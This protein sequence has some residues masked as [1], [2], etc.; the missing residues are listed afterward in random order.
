MAGLDPQA[1]L[2]RTLAAAREVTGARYAAV[3]VLNEER[4]ELQEFLT[5]GMDEQTRLAIGEWPRGRGVLGVLI[6]EPHPLRLS[7]VGQ[8]PLSF[9]FPEGHPAMSSFLGV[10]ILIEGVAS[11]S[12]YVAEKQGGEFTEADEEAAVILA[13]W[14][15]SAIKN[16]RRYHTFER[17]RVELEHTVRGLDT[18]PDG[19]NVIGNG[20]GLERVLELI[21]ER[22][23]ALIDARGTNEG[24]VSTHEEKLLREF[25]A[26][27]AGAVAMAQTEES[28]RLRGLMAATDAE[29]SRWARELHDETLQGLGALRL[30]LASA[31][32][33]GDPK[34]IELAV[35]EAVGHVDQEIENLH[36]IISDLRPAALDELGLRPALEALLERRSEHGELTIASR[37]VLPDPKAAEDRLEPEI[38]S[39]VYRV[40][41]EALTNI[42][43]HANARNARV[44]VTASGGAVLVEVQDDGIGFAP[45]A[46]GW[47]FGLVGI[48]ERVFLAGGTVTIESGKRGS[49]RT[50]RAPGPRARRHRS[51]TPRAAPVVVR[52]AR[53]RRGLRFRAC[54]GCDHVS[55]STCALRGG[56]C[57]RSQPTWTQARSVHDTRLTPTETILSERSPP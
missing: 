15:A 35:D 3:G 21:I 23:R 6:N 7:H 52:R 47:G 20:T 12:L 31:R 36:A 18:T 56:P 8:H 10:P 9:G 24:G 57:M 53:A 41:Q 45:D 22:G 46:R 30:L 4:T 42:A 55:V 49:A 25:A 39:T 40:V 11:G 48:R 26:S 37:L 29:R 54:R 1:A 16:A 34:Q 50:R 19:A 51:A 5:L 27:A 44:A 14:A 28:D 17:P 33:R 32:R 13:D 2:D 38:E 43:K